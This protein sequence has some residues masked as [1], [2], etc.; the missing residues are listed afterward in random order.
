MEKGCKR[1]ILNKKE[2]CFIVSTAPTLPM[3]YYLP[4]IHKSLE[5][6]PGRP[7]ISGIG[8]LM[9]RANEYIDGFLQPL[10]KN[11]PAFLNHKAG[12]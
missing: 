8:S 9:S 5:N 12:Y 10:V 4:K 1:E 3:M 11:T 2:K 6:P 7:V